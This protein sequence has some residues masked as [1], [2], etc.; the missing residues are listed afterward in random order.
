[1]ADIE[2]SDGSF[3]VVPRRR[4]RGHEMP[5]DNFFRSLAEEHKSR[6]IGV[7]LSGTLSDGALG[8]RAIKAEGGVTF[9]QDEQSAKLHDMPRAAI[10]AG[11]VDFIF[12]PEKI[13]LELIQMGK[14]PYIRPAPQ[15]QAEEPRIEGTDHQRVLAILR[16]T[17]G[18][19]FSNY[20][21]T[22]VK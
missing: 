7:V 6:A 11:S 10:A 22:T 9:A 2:L 4:D 19:D 20:R 21:Q 8:L 12:P 13:A 3:Q 18:V 5:I 14:H 15:A 17:T 1:N 16:T